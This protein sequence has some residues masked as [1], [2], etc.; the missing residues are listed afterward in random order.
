MPGNGEFLASQRAIDQ[1]RQRRFG[2]LELN[3]PHG[4]FALHMTTIVTYRSLA[5][6]VQSD[7]RARG[8]PLDD[9]PVIRGDDG[10]DQIAGNPGAA[11]A[12]DPRRRKQ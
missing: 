3:V 11:T 9:A 7:R 8:L 5:A 4:R 10:I 2:V 1:T 12:C 6:R